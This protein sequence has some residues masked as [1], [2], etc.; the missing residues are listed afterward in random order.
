VTGLQ[1][2]RTP[3]AKSDENPPRRLDFCFGGLS[4]DRE[5]FSAGTQQ[6]RGPADK[7][8]KRRDGPGRR[9][10]RLDMR[11]RLFL[12]AGAY[13]LGVGQTQRR[14][15]LLKEN[16]AA[17]QR[18]KKDHVKRRPQHREHDP[19][20]SRTRAYVDEHAALR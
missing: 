6:W 14:D 18:L 4:F 3:H 2:L 15:A 12:S 13:D 8:I 20:Q 17:Q 5:Q 1:N 16:G 10:V 19:G 7:A 9:D 11:R